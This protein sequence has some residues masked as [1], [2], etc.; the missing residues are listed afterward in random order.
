MFCGEL[1]DTTASTLKQF[2]QFYRLPAN[3]IQTVLKKVKDRVVLYCVK[4][5]NTA[6]VQL[7]NNQPLFPLKKEEKKNQD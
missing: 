3:L 1:F 7:K 4:H 6:T 5:D 2:Q